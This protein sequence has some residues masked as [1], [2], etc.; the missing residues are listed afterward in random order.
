MT[1]ET[2]R[3]TVSVSLTREYEFE[4]ENVDRDAAIEAA[5]RQAAE[6]ASESL[7]TYS[8]AHLMI[9]DVT[10]DKTPSTEDDDK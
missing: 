10:T 2:H 9:E 1:D 6:A 8:G 3:V 4:F 7:L 5:F